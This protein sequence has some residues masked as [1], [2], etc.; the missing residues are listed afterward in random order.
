[1][2][3]RG[4]EVRTVLGGILST[5]NYSQCCSGEPRHKR[6]M[7]NKQIKSAAACLQRSKGRESVVSHLHRPLTWPSYYTSLLLQQ[8][9]TTANKVTRVKEGK[10]RESSNPKNK[11]ALYKSIVSS[12]LTYQSMLKT[13]PHTPFSQTSLMSL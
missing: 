12:T 3:Q 9:T 1:V 10:A 11:S 13:E 7:E 2:L 6:H 4:F 5:S 8:S